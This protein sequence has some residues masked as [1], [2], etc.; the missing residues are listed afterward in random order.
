MD[1]KKIERIICLDIDDCI[2]PSPYPFNGFRD[3]QMTLDQLKINIYRLEKLIEGTDSKIFLTSS[4]S[5]V[6]TLNNVILEVTHQMSDRDM[7]AFELIKKLETH[8]IGISCGDRFKDIENLDDQNTTIVAFDDWDLSKINNK[9]VKFIPTF[10]SLDNT[11]LREAY[12]HL[13]GLTM[14]IELKRDKDL[15]KTSKTTTQIPVFNEDGE[16][17][18]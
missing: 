13:K 4:W 5:V 9:F 14:N 16:E 8:I 1:P 17:I 11:I 15:S 12:A 2:L 18:P 7:I 3:E 10:G 6:L